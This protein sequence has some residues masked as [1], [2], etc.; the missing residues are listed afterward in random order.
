[1]IALMMQ[2]VSE[3]RN[4]FLLVSKAEYGYKMGFL[5]MEIPFIIYFVVSKS[6]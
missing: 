3:V 1:M 2:V 4:G 5:L 6:N